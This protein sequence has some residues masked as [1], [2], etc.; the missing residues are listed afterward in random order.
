MSRRPEDPA[1]AIRTELPADYGAV[2]RVHELAFGRAEEAR[3]VD[4][5]REAGEVLVSLVAMANDS[6]CG[7]VLFSRLPIHARPPIAGAA[8]APVGVLPAQQGRGIGS[9]LICEGLRQ[10]RDNAVEAVVVLG[11]PDYYVRFGFSSILA[12]RLAA[13][14]SGPAFMAQELVPGALHRGGEVRYP[15]AFARLE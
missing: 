9:A 2:R 1:I 4:E 11:R 5:L 13:P 14:Y 3:L 8:L 7:H 10:C 15:A 6:V 12:E